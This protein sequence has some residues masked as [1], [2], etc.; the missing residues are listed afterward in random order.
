MLLVI[1]VTNVTAAAKTIDS[2]SEGFQQILVDLSPNTTGSNG[3]Y[4]TMTSASSISTQRDVYVYGENNSALATRQIDVTVD[5]AA[6]K[7][8]ISVPD[9]VDNVIVKIEWDGADDLD[10][11]NSVDRD[12]LSPINFTTF[13]DAIHMTALNHDVSASVTL[14]LYSGT[15]S[16]SDQT[17][18][19]PGS[20][21]NGSYDLVFFL[22]QFSRMTSECAN[23]ANTSSITAVA[24]IIETDADLDMA[25]SFLQVDTVEEYGDLPT[26]TGYFS[27]A[28]LDASHGV[29]TLHLGP[30][31]D[32]ESTYNASEDALGDDDQNSDDEDGVTPSDDWTAAVWPGTCDYGIK[33]KISVRVEGCTSGACRLNGWIDWDQDGVFEDDAVW[34]YYCGGFP[35]TTGEASERL[36]T[37]TLITTDPQV[38]PVTF[39]VPLDVMAINPTNQ[40]YAR[41]RV[42]EDG[43]T[44]GDCSAPTGDATAGEVEDYNWDL[45]PTD[46]KLSAFTAS[47]QDGVVQV[48]WTTSAEVDTA[49]FNLLR[50]T[51]EDGEYSQVNA[52]LIPVASPGDTW[53]GEYSF[54]DEN[55]VAGESYFYK[56]EEIEN[57]GAANTYG[58]VATMGESSSPNSVSVSAVKGTGQSL[59]AVGLLVAAGAVVLASRKR[60]S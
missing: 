8:S 12:G 14:Q 54:T 47:W 52:A 1:V 36:I 29:S 33:G 25:V 26:G 49:G 37:N 35:G 46:V 59:W 31:F 6:S 10:T 22:S 13:G 11:Y 28:V 7:L 48:D 21:Q 44:G 56:L 51:S 43:G 32:F 58:P 5:T 40:Y 55:V 53:G 57:G 15:D 20:Y 2:F 42:C 34:A 38:V 27:T 23:A 24:L 4:G 18:A 17:I 9:D 16:C 45:D 30:S 60:E 19:L 50:S 41:F 39:F 3:G